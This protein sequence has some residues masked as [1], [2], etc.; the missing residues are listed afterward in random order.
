MC[1]IAGIITQSSREDAMGRLKQMLNLQTHR[2]P[3]G[4]G[5]EIVETTKGNPVCLG[6]RRL[7]VLD[8]SDH[9]H[10]PMINPDTGDIIIYNGEIYNFGDLKVSLET[11]GFAFRSSSDTEVLLRAYQQWGL[12]FLDKIKGMFAFAIWDPKTQG[13]LLAR[14]QLGI[15]PLYYSSLNDQGFVFASE[16][17][18]VLASG[19]VPQKMDTRSLASYLA[20]GAVQEPFTMISGISSLPPGTRIEVD[21]SGKVTRQ[22]IY[23]EIPHPCNQTSIISSSQLLEEGSSIF[24]EAVRRHMTSD[25]PLGVF[26]SSGL[27]STAVLALARKVSPEVRA[28]TVSFPQDPASDELSLAS[29][30]ARRL[31]VDQ[32][33]CYV[34]ET[35]GLKWAQEAL[36]AMDQ[37]SLDGLNTY[38]VSKAVRAQGIVV[39]LSGQGGDEIFGGYSSSRMV[40]NWYSMSKALSFLPPS[41]RAALARVATIGRGTV[42]RD[43]AIDLANTEPDLA[44]LYFQYRRLI[45]ERGMASLGLSYA[46]LALTQSYHSRELDPS[47]TLVSG[48][49]PASIRLLE[50]TFYLGNTLL[51]DG[52]VFGMANSVEIR[53]P[54][55]DRD[56]VEWACRLPSEVF[57]ASGKSNKP[58]LRAMFASYYNTAQLKMAKS[59]FTPPLYNWLHGHFREMAEDSLAT[60]KTAGFLTPGGIDRIWAAYLHNPQ[61]AAWSRVWALVTLSFWINRLTNDSTVS[62]T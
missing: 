10:Q 17:R 25:V 8:L 60:L 56:L 2:G 31:H 33:K 5:Y 49:H 29:E 16:V 7:A 47:R 1:G 43:K 35:E 45:S 12:N 42:A 20:Y 44:S 32:Y 52:D 11:L 36:Q 28:F 30:T 54:F 57:L 59:G 18:A 23:W 48:D 61:S 19:L 46:E 41:W 9:G 22:S 39:A 24:Q 53:V 58:L 50:T 38:I 3:D 27:D 21:P 40:P 55:L 14:D 37:P 26:L 34:N 15:K 6:N 62:V 13:L 51:R 4:V